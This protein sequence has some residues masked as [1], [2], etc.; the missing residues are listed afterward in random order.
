MSSRKW[1][2]LLYALIPP[3]LRGLDEKV[4]RDAEFF[5][6]TPPQISNTLSSRPPSLAAAYIGAS[7]PFDNDSVFILPSPEVI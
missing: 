3:I 2:L 7:F 6:F 1:R 5:K 4:D